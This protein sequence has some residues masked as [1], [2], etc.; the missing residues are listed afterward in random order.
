MVD[1]LAV[2][3]GDHIARLQARALARALRLHRADQRAMR[4]R[5]TEGL[6]ELLADILN[7]DADAAAVHL[8]GLHELLFDVERDIDRNGERHA[9]V[10]ARAAVDL[11]VDTDHL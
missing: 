1:V 7:G 6:R 3:A 5:Q 11:S 10:A 8:A 4:S 2:D 9:H